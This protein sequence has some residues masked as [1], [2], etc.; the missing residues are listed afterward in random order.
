[1]SDRG[2]RNSLT[3]TLS[4]IKK[5]TYTFLAIVGSLTLATFEYFGLVSESMD[6]AYKI[7]LGFGIVIIAVAYFKAS[8]GGFWSILLCVF[9]APVM[10]TSAFSG[11]AQISVQ[12]EKEAQ[13]NKSQQTRI[14]SAD[15][16]LSAA[17]KLAIDHKSI[18][19]N[20]GIFT[21]RLDAIKQAG[22]INSKSSLTT[23]ERRAPALS[24]L[25]GLGIRIKATDFET[26]I[27]ALFT[28][29]L[30]IAIGVMARAG[31]SPTTRKPQGDHIVADSQNIG[32][33]VGDSA[34]RTKYTNEEAEVAVDAGIKKEGLTKVSQ[35][36]VQRLIQTFYKSNVG[37]KNERAAKLAKKKNAE[38]ST[39]IVE[40][41]ENVIDFIKRKL[42]VKK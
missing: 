18:K 8:R 36:D 3:S 24:A 38:L 4:S 16:D 12:Q 6:T 39:E 7:A 19:D 2:M 1:M 26:Y 33:S 14:N 23:E 9:F 17:A 25:S 15:R 40:H 13:F 32:D 27:S 31:L 42:G 35:D 22:E 37:I 10:L 21:A 20:N 34:I 11:R 5:P 29:A 28:L 30:F 41:S